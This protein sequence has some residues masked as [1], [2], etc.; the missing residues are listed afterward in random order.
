[1]DNA[2]LSW[3]VPVIMLAATGTLGWV[4]KLAV[5][6]NTLGN[7]NQNQDEKI[8]DLKDSLNEHKNHNQGQH[9]E[10]YKSRNETAQSLVKLTTLFENMDKK[11]DSLIEQGQRRRREDDGN[12]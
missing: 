8:K 12:G 4:I 9:E 1:M 3:L 10:L 7:E 2:L 6:M 5:D 11:L